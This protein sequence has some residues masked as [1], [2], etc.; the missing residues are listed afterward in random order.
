MR[1]TRYISIHTIPYHNLVICGDFNIHVNKPTET[2][3]SNFN[4]ILDTFSL[5]QSVHCP[6][7]KL[8]NTLDLILHDNLVTIDNINI[9][10]PDR[11]DHYQIFF[12]INCNIKINS[13]REITFRNF[14]NVNLDNF[15]VDIEN[16]SNIFIQ[17][18]DRN[19]FSSS[20][21]LFNQMFGDIVESH[22]PLITKQ[23]NVNTQPGWR[24]QEFKYA[25]SQR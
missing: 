25:R 21:S 17:T 20:L 22:A 15:K 7:H 8:G 12:D 1:L 19:N 3:V 6:T 13:K 2:F 18:C 23:V 10:K 11:G 16:A 9:E 4:D 5:S 14:K 24:D